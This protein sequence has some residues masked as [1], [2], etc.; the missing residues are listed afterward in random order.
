MAIS[1]AAKPNVIAP[2][3]P[4]SYGRIKDNPGDNTGTPVDEEVYGDF[5]QFFAPLLN[6]GAITPNNLRE[7]GSNGYQYMQALYSVINIQTDFF[8]VVGSNFLEPP[9]Q[10]SFATSTIVLGAPNDCEFS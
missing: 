1:L 5:H 7:N 10:N 6:A 2:V 8:H 4:Y 9:F 3:F